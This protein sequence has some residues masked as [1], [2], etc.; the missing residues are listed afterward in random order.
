M[1]ERLREI[2]DV[3]SVVALA[4]AWGRA[5]LAYPRLPARFPIHFGFTGRADGWGS[6]RML[7]L[8]PCLGL[9]IYLCLGRVITAPGHPGPTPPVVATALAW[10]RFEIIAM[11]LYI[12]TK[13]IQ[14][15]RGRAAGLGAAFLPISLAVILTTTWLLV[16]ALP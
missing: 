3:G 2:A 13:S 10:L 6:K 12:E 7:W 16:K 15:A 8:L 11:F 14:V 9:G 5:V 4:V 1:I